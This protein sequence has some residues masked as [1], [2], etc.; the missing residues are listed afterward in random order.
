MALACLGERP[1][2]SASQASIQSIPCIQPCQFLAQTSLIPLSATHNKKVLVVPFEGGP[3]TAPAIGRMA[4]PCII[5]DDDPGVQ[6][7]ACLLIEQGAGCVVASP[8]ASAHPSVLRGAILAFP[9]IHRISGYKALPPLQL[10]FGIAH[11][12]WGHSSPAEQSST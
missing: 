11:S 2:G 3:L 5:H 7:K 8:I 10:P 1:T 4:I 9:G 12:A 6:I